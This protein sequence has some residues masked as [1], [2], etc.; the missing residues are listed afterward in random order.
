M[1]AKI[2]SLFKEPLATER[3]QD[4]ET[5]DREYKYWRVRS[6]Y[7]MYIGYV[8]FYFTRKNLSPVLHL[9]SEDLNISMIELGILSSIFYVTYGVGKFVSGTLADKSNIRIFMPV[10]LFFA[11]VVTLIF[12]S[13]QSLLALSVAWGLNGIFQSMG[14]P[15]VAKGLVHWFS[16]SERATKWTLWSSS[17]TA[18]TFLIGMII[19]GLLKYYGWRSAFYAPGV[20][21]IITSFFLYNR[22][23]DRPSSLGLPPIE[24]YKNDPIPVTIE[25]SGLTHFEILKKYVFSNRYIWYLCFA[26][27]FVYLVRFG[28]L[29]WATKF[30]YDVRGIDKI[31]VTFMWALMPLF[32]VPGGIVAGVI[33]DRCFG[34]R[35]TPVNLIYL[36]FLALSIFGFYQLASMENFFTTCLL[37]GCIGFFVDG[38]QNLIGGVQV[39][40]VTAKEA[41]SAACGFSGLF[42]YMGAII[43]GVG[44]GYVT[45]TFGWGAMY[46][47]CV[48]SCMIAAFFVAL[49]GAAEKA[50]IE[51]NGS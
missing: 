41:A 26:Y 19:T 23:R 10:G 15:P 31:E 44:L 8:V 13:L 33:S 30:M 45:E 3:I 35:C 14:F 24:E 28:T 11:S 4:K 2:L 51:K 9:F 25:E 50:H 29:D 38:P 18:G 17:H 39:S 21:G 36:F 16:P 48:V 49:T 12:P 20:I 32:G 46:G 27:V 47:V 37:L 1:R 22:L 42:G 43:S 7:S 5:V 34:G 6:F 40:R